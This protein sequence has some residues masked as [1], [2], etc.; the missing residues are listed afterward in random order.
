MKKIVLLSLLIIVL[1]SSPLA[2]IEDKTTPGEPI[3]KLQPG[4]N[5]VHLVK[6]GVRF[7]SENGSLQPIGLY[8]IIVGDPQKLE[9]ATGLNKSH[10]FDALVFTTYQDKKDDWHKIRVH[11]PVKDKKGWKESIIVKKDRL[12]NPFNTM[13]DDLLKKIHFFNI[14]PD[15]DEVAVVYVIEGT[16]FSDCEKIFDYISKKKLRS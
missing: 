1:I 11:R 13:P 2:A 14:Y 3:D 4:Q 9:Q 8:K 6:Y 7:Y 15:S 5:D 16:K 10:G 12:P